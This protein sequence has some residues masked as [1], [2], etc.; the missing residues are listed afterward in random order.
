MS[1]FICSFGY[2]LLLY[3]ISED[4]L[5][6]GASLLYRLAKKG[7]VFHRGCNCVGHITSTK[8]VAGTCVKKITSKS[9][10]YRNAKKKV[11][12]DQ[13]LTRNISSSIRSDQL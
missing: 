11:Y 3:S 2:I 4:L 13:N 6:P 9:C 8:N 10:Y 7:T 5:E 12:V 1:H